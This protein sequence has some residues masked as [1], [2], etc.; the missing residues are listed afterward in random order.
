MDTRKLAVV[1]LKFGS[2]KSALFFPRATFSDT[3]AFQI[4]LYFNVMSNHNWN[5]I[6]MNTAQANRPH[7]VDRG[8]S[9][10]MHEHED[11]LAQRQ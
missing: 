9:K 7:P 6:E 4:A 10:V 11:S 5:W 3:E 8:G 1:I 2:E